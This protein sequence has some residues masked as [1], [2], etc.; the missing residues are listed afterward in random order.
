LPDWLRDLA[1][2]GAALEEAE[3]RLDKAKEAAESAEDA[4]ATIR[5]RTRRTEAASINAAERLKE[6]Y[7]RPEEARAAI[8]AFRERSG[9]KSLLAA[10]SA[11]PEQ[12][13]PLRE[14][15]EPRLG[16][17]FSRRDTRK[18]RQT[19]PL[20]SVALEHD[21]A[22]AAKAP[23]DEERMAAPERVQKAHRELEAAQQ[24]RRALPAADSAV[25]RKE[26]AGLFRAV[27]AEE[28][29]GDQRL[30]QVLTTTLPETA[31][32]VARALDALHGEEHQRTREPRGDVGIDF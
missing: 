9:D 5:E 22:T 31:R 8:T 25:Y 6:V 32:F 1:Q 11:D 29:G 15:R 26:L 3:R 13:G 24:A 18:A 19:A 12:F 2:Q 10:V 17:L 28:P 27:A 20:L 30:A 16:G 21:Y 14:E 23:S 7:A 4:L